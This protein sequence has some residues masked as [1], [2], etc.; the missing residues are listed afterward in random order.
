MVSNNRNARLPTGVELDA[1]AALVERVTGQPH[2]MER[3][4]HRDRVRELLGGG[5]LEPGEPVHRHNLDRVAPGLFSFAQPCLEGLF[6][7]ALDHV[8]Q[9]RRTSAVADAG[10]VDDH[11]H[12]LV[13][14]P[15]VA[16][17]VFVDPDHLH[18]SNLSG[19]SIN[20]RLPSARTA[21]LAV[22]HDTP[23]P[24]ATL[25]TVRCWHTTASSAHRR[26]RRDSFA[27]GSAAG[28]VSW[29]HTC[30]HPVHRYR[31]T[32]TSSVVGRQPH[33]SC[34]S[35][36]VTVSRDV[37]SQPQRRHQL[38]GSTTRQ[39]RTARSGTR[40]CP[41]TSRPR[42][43][44]RQNVVKSGAVKIASGTSRSSR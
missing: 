22:F 4:H 7:A 18:P 29:R 15:R 16:P 24:S 21:S 5:G 28:L 37:P 35:R 8:Q 40:R 12:V 25:A 17:H 9:P 6:R 33:G 1:S 31:R 36:R 19:S 3:I 38:S 43:F 13:P 42:S 10:Q 27:R 20:T 30:P 34:A 44:N 14:S 23:S 39:A 32:V 26:P 2:D 11:G 41:T